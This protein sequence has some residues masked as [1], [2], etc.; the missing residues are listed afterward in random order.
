[1]KVTKYILTIV[2]LLFIAFMVYIA[3][4]PNAYKISREKEIAVSKENTY[5]YINDFSTWKKWFDLEDYD[6]SAKLS[7][8]TKPGNNNPSFTWN[9]STLNGKITTSKSILSDTLYQDIQIGNSTHKITW[10]FTSNKNGTKVNWSMEGLN[11]FKWKLNNF[12]QSGIDVVYGGLFEKGLNQIEKNLISELNSFKIIQ[13]GILTKNAT[14]FIQQ[15]DS[16]SLD[17]LQTNYKKALQNTMQFV[18]NNSIKTI[19]IPFIIVH[20][21]NEIKNY[22]VYSLC[23]PTE[24]E[25]LIPIE[26]KIKNGYFDTYIAYKT[27]LIGDYLHLKKARKK[28]EEAILKLDYTIDTNN[29]YIEIYKVSLPET[30]N[31]SKWVT[32]LYYPI[33]KKFVKPVII[34]NSSLK[35]DSIKTNVIESIKPEI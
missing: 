14:Y 4:Q 32:E 33:K 11:S 16:C 10:I 15:K 2:F 13:N 22:I 12:L 20:E 34:T 1:M 9:S 5:D 23:I 7:Y 31:A 17:N 28:T 18:K 24:N 8:S 3:T 29:N 30:K 25:I 35:K 27:I 19:N 6:K 21:R 26:S